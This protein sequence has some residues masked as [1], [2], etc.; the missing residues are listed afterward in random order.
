MGPK[1]GIWGA[2]IKQVFPW[3]LC[4]FGIFEHL[5]FTRH[6]TGCFMSIIITTPYTTTVRSSMP[7][8]DTISSLV[9]DWQQEERSSMTW[10]SPG[11]QNQSEP[12][13]YPKLAWGSGIDPL[14]QA[15]H[16]TEWLVPKKPMSVFLG[17]LGLRLPQLTFFSW[18]FFLF[19]TQLWL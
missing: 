9:I 2:N 15:D 16:F 11:V 5:T 1:I 19:Y 8:Y 12:L 4:I 18:F 6:C 10:I 7:F 14:K 3:Y 13:T 17:A